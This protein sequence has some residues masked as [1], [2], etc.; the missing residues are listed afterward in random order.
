MRA[1]AWIA[2]GEVKVFAIDQMEAAKGW[3]VG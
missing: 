3:V 1:F 2:P